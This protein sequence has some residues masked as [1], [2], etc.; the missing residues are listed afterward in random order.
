MSGNIPGPVPFDYTLWE[1]TYP[2]FSA[3]TEMQATGYWGIAQLYLNN[4]ASSPV[5]D[6]SPGGA[7][8]TLLNMLTAHIAQLLAPI[9][10]Q[11]S[12]QQ[13]GRISNVSQGSVSIALDFPNQAARD[14]W[15]NQTKYGAMYLAAIKP[16]MQGGRYNPGPQPYLGVAPFGRRGF[17]GFPGF[18]R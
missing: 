18:L 6:N 15:Y 13:V 1:A 10:G 11:P 16:Y 8:Q 2:E 4:S 7:R 17:G 9:N 5:T 3:V 12:S 14:A